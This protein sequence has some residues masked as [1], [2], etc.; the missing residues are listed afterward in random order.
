MSVITSILATA[1]TAELS[2]FGKIAE[3]RV[4]VIKRIEQ[5]KDNKKTLEAA[6]QSLIANTPWLIDPQ[7]SPITANQSF[8][9]LKAEFQKF[10]KERTGKR[11]VLDNFV[12]PAKRAD[13]VLSS[14]DN[15]VQ[16]I[17]E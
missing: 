16:I 4:K 2:A 9:T 10:Y 5:L 6:F 8:A 7:W 13:F 3:D 1:R 14:Q 12:D 17:E 11:L 15:V